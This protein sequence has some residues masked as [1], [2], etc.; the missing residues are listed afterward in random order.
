MSEPN[1]IKTYK[2]NNP[3]CNIESK[4][5][6]LLYVNHRTREMDSE[7]WKKQY[8]FVHVL[9]IIITLNVKKKLEHGIAMEINRKLID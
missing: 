2:Y 8:N 6:P 1:V 3:A 7:R 5:I 4:K 9:K